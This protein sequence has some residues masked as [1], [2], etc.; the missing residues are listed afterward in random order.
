MNEKELFKVYNLIHNQFKKYSIKSKATELELLVFSYFSR[1]HHLESTQTQSN[2]YLQHIFEYTNYALNHFSNLNTK[3]KIFELPEQDI[4]NYL[5][6]KYYSTIKSA[7][8]IEILEEKTKEFFVSIYQSLYYKIDKKYLKENQTKLNLFKLDFSS[9]ER[10]L[11][12]INQ[13]AS[14]NGFE[15]EWDEIIGNNEAKEGL[16][17]IAKMLFCYDLQKKSNPWLKFYALPKSILL[18]GPPGTGK[19]SLINAMISEMYHLSLKSGKPFQF[20]KIDNTFKSKY[21]GESVKK[22]SEILKQANSSTQISLVIMEDI[23]T[24]FSSRNDNN[25]FY[26]EAHL[27]NYLMNFI[28]GIGISYRGNVLYLSTTNNVKRIDQALLSRLIQKRYKVLGPT[29][30]EEYVKLMKT[31]LKPLIELNL[32]NVNDLEYRE[33]AKYF[34]TERI[35]AREVTNYLISIINDH[36]NKLNLENYV[37]LSY[38]S[39]LEKLQ[40]EL[41]PIDYEALKEKLDEYFKKTNYL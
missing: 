18:E 19:T 27:L 23:D 21:Y 6:K 33:L 20:F 1:I 34:L 17:R 16:K 38:D 39:S 10:F 30:I 5:A 28:E 15:F 3:T 29:T 22:L 7:P 40:N 26:E 35:S 12:L 36:I 11:K 9:G 24:I 25:L 14:L 13:Y 37:K 8:T 32:I 2:I 4:E 31:K 41:K